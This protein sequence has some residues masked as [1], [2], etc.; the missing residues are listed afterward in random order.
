MG[1]VSVDLHWNGSSGS[2]SNDGKRE[3]MAVYK[4]VTDN[5]RDQTATICDYF[6]N[7][8]N[9]PRLNS[10]YQYGNDYDQS[11]T[12]KRI[13]PRRDAK[14]SYQWEVVL[15][16]ETPTG[17][18]KDDDP[19]DRQQK[20]ADGKLTNDP[21]KWLEKWDFGFTQISVPVEKATYRSGL[22]GASGVAMAGGTETPV[23]NSAFEPFV[24]PPE[25]EIDLLT[26]RRQFYKSTFAEATAAKYQNKVNS[27]PLII[28]N[29]KLG[30]S[31]L[32]DAYQLRC[33]SIG[34]YLEWINGAPWWY[35]QMEFLKHPY[36]WRSQIVDRGLN[37]R[38][39]TG[40]ITG[41]G[42]SFEAGNFVNGR[43]RLVPI[44][45]ADGNA[46][47]NPVLLNGT[48]EPL[49]TSDVVP[50]PVY[51]TYSIYDEV[52]FPNDLFGI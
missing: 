4:V 41:R 46:I 1:V 20:D 3:Y 40:Y 36:G 29:G 48:G 8:G 28:L 15:N 17:D 50:A 10:F 9:L 34:A 43:A 44:L 45:D 32:A 31:F 30:Y 23:V 19:P 26:I 5:V 6:Q 25:K 12:C 2:R 24:P 35:W 49:I 22:V 7:A 52:N 51:L 21:S 33:K 38:A 39:V 14:S 27:N 42:T 16:Y 47:R 11:V 37:R 13:S 18:K